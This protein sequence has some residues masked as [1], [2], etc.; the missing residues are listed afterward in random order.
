MASSFS[1]GMLITW[2]EVSSW[3]PR[4][5]IQVV[6]GVR[7][8]DFVEIPKCVQSASIPSNEFMHV[9]DWGGPAIRK[10]SK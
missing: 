4:K 7:F 10:S 2:V 1:G 6:G 3:M 5:V 8:S 9:G